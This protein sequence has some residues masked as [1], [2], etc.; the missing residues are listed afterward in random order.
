MAL[1][2]WSDSYSVGN[3][4]IDSQHKELINMIN[5]LHEKMQSG[6]GKQVVGSIVD[7]L[8]TYT[9]H[10]FQDEETIFMATDYPEKDKHL[11][12]H[13]DFEKEVSELKKKL[14]SNENVGSITL[15]T[16]LKNWLNDHILTLDKSYKDYIA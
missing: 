13:R 9:I 8:I 5:R 10:H 4:K 6:E 16:I 1:I 3:E 12:A 2:N 15:G 11:K 14:L 7:S